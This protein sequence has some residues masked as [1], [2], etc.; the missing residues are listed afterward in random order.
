MK[1][2]EYEKMENTILVDLKGHQEIDG[3]SYWDS[4]MMRFIFG[5]HDYE[6]HS[7]RY[8]NPYNMAEVTQLIVDTVDEINEEDGTTYRVSDFIVK[9]KGFK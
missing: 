2:K 7:G 5:D 1:S 6:Y 3:E 9:I 8:K 4:V